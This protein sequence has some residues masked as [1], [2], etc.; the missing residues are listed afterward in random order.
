L[1]SVKI[2]SGVAADLLEEDAFVLEGALDRVCSFEKGLLVNKHLPDFFPIKVV[3][4]D[5]V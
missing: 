1:N 2:I 4:G 3:V 5:E